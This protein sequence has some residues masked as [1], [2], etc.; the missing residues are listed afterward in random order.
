MRSG[1]SSQDPPSF[2]ASRWLRLRAA[3]ETQRQLISIV[4]LLAKTSSSSAFSVPRRLPSIS[5]CA[6]TERCLLLTLYTTPLS[7]NGRKVLALCRFL[8][9]DPIIREINVYEG[10]G[11][12]ASYLAINPSGTIPFLTDGALALPESNAILLYLDEAYGHH[13]ANSADQKDRARVASW[14]FWE[15]AHWQTALIRVLAG[16]VGHRLLPAAVPEPKSSPDWD[17]AELVPVLQK[18]DAHLRSRA[19]MVGNA[20]TIADLSIAGMTTY[21][22]IC[23]FPAHRYASIARWCESLNEHPAWR[24]TASPLWSRQK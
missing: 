12:H 24:E 1:S 16:T 4:L 22:D 20:I 21:F 15:S 18:L 13:R 5:S 3:T 6:I 8:D 2:G 7:A 23:D 14:L 19:F 17:D 11:Q 9:L 10:A